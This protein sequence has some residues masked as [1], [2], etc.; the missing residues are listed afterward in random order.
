MPVASGDIL[1][2]LL[3][4]LSRSLSPS[5]TP[6]QKRDKA[7]DT[8]CETMEKFVRSYTAQTVLWYGVDL[9]IR[10]FLGVLKGAA[11]CLVGAGSCYEPPVDAWSTGMSQARCLGR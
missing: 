9:R 11:G 5:Q 10:C 7:F 6:C 3:S 2:L 8:G 1:R 4:N